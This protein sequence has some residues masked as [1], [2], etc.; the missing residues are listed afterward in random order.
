[1]GVLA[2]SIH[3]IHALDEIDGWVRAGQIFLKRCPWLIFRDIDKVRSNTGIVRVRRIRRLAGG[4]WRRHK[5][6]CSGVH[7]CGVVCR[8]CLEGWRSAP[9]RRAIKRTGGTDIP[10]SRG[11]SC[12]ATELA[13]V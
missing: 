5:C 9:V 1:M 3:D 8:A 6:G 2:V 13:G 11:G 4:D 12:M 10:W 7:G